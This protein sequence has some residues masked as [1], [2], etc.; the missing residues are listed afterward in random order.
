MDHP[1]L[2]THLGVSKAVL[3]KAKKA[4][5]TPGLHYTEKRPQIYTAAGIAALKLHFG[6]EKK[7][8]PPCCDGPCQC[9]TVT[10]R[11]GRMVLATDATSAEWQLEVRMP[12]LY[13]IGMKIPPA[14]YTPSGARPRFARQKGRAPRSRGRW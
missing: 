6:I 10:G 4:A 12:A 11:R 5:L 14:R 1:T 13:T 8:P 3:G 9:L 2:A 7:E